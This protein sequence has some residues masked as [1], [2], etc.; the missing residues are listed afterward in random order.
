MI[1]ELDFSRVYSYSFG[2][3]FNLAKDLESYGVHRI[4]DIV[5][6]HGYLEPTILVLHEPLYTW[7]GY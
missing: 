3:D 6:L 7:E 1:S 4:K 2:D 5:F